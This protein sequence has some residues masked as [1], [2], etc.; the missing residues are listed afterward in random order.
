MHRKVWDT[1]TGDTLHTFQHQHIVRAV[2]ITPSSSHIFTAG[3]EK[4]LRRFDLSRPDAEPEVFLDPSSSS[5]GSTSHDGNIKS[6]IWDEKRRLVISASEDK[7]IKWWDPRAPSGPVSLFSLPAGLASVDRGFPSSSEDL[8]LAIST[9][10]KA[11][12][13]DAETRTPITEHELPYEVSACALEPG[14]RERFVTGSAN[15]G[16]VRVYDAATGEKK[17]ENKGAQWHS[18]TEDHADSL[19]G[20]T[21]RP[22]ALSVVFPRRRAVRLRI[23]RRWVV[24]LA[25]FMPSF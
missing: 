6:V 16:W 22:G 3:M 13:L 17:E 8:H 7:T 9:G 12:F 25:D 4:K 24:L 10:K 15:D 14:K 18:G 11:I 5:G 2:D 20:R 19:G 23:G 21:P 1:Y